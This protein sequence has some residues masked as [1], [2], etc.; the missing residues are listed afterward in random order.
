MARYATAGRSTI[1]GT[2]VRGLFSLYA[3]AAVTPKVREI[4]LWNTT[5]TALAVAVVRFTSAGTQGTGL[6]EVPLDDP[7]HVA[8]STTFAGH[9]ADPAVS[10]PIR[11]AS[12][13]A[14]VGAGVIW[15][16]GGNG[17]EIPAATTAGVGVIIP[18]GTGQICDY[19]VEWEE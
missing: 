7:V 8:I 5:A 16:F 12:L 1:A 18:T 6:T 3:T 2:T 14:A 10:A 17:L 4:G 9:T 15:T 13:A 11:Q 19:Y